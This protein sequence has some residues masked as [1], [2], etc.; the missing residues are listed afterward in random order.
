MKMIQY[1]L[2]IYQKL[3]ILDLNRPHNTVGYTGEKYFLTFIDDYYSVNWHVYI[4]KNISYSENEVANNYY[5][6]INLVEDLTGKKI[7]TLHD[8][9]TVH[10][11]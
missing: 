8:V 7:K 9:I 1:K 10:N 2:A 5:E 11:I 3:Y 6:Y 4:V